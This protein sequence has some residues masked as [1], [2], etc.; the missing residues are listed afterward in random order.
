MNAHYFHLRRKPFAFTLVELLVST[1]L[2]GLL[3]A[4]LLSSVNQSQQVMTRTTAKV[5]QFQ[6]ARAA[7]DVMTRRLSQAKL[8]TYY[9]AFDSDSTTESS[10]YSFTRESDL[11]I[12]SGPAATG[13]ASA[14][15]I[16]RSE[17]HTSELQ[18]Q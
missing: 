11:Q 4:L 5:K 8:N 17:E 14:P 10:T 13:A 18:S 3:M 12:L 6:A 15:G 1:T 16:F 9:R 2:I 7:F